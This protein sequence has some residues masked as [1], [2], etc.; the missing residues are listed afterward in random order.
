MGFEGAIAAP[1]CGAIIR[2]PSCGRTTVEAWMPERIAGRAV[3]SYNDGDHRTASGSMKV[4]GFA[5]YSGSGKTTLVEQ[6]IPRFVAAG[7]RLG[8]VKHAH[9]HFDIDHP[10]KDS[11]RH[12]QAGATE[13]LV[14]SDERWALMHELR[15]G[16]QPTLAEHL[17]RFSPCDLVLVEGFKKEPLP[18]LEVHRRD[19][20]APVLFDADD[21]IVAVATDEPLAT[22]LPQ[23]RI[24][25]Y[26]GIVRFILE[27]VGLVEGPAP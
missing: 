22:D 10:G 16:P 8:V 9:H 26:D 13:V 11:W 19:T 12:R 5:G 25:D 27:Y 14:T 18:K 24:D 23:L 21:N 6:L 3:D 2:M 1:G 4:F 7:Y 20:G 17:V 15:G